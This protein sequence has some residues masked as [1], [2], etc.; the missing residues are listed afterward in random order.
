MEW[1]FSSFPCFINDSQV[2]C[3]IF[4]IRIFETS[5]RFPA[6]LRGASPEIFH[7]SSVHTHA[8]LLLTSPS[9]GVHT[10]PPT[11]TV[12]ITIHSRGRA[13]CVFGQRYDDAYLLGYHAE[14]FHCPTRLNVL[15]TRPVPFPNLWPPW[16]FYS[17]RSWPF[18]EYHLTAIRR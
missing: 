3:V 9:R 17:R 15:P 7:R 12:C 1:G 18:P 6:K 11:S 2:K 10:S 8:Q 16:I 13:S 4:F 14:C 5:F